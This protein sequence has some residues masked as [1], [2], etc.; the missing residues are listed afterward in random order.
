MAEL[1]LRELAKTYPGGTRAVAGVSLHVGERE[2]VVLVGP[3]GC[4][5]TTLLRL[6]AGLE[7]ATAGRVLLGGRDVTATPPAARNVAMVFQKYA[8]Y[9]FKSVAENLA[10]GPRLR[11]VPHVEVEQRVAETAD[12]LGLRELLS[13]YPSQLSGGQQQRVALGRALVRRPELFLFDEPLSNLDANLRRDLRSEIRLLQRESATAAVYVTHDQEEAMAL[14]DRLV[15]MHC[16]QF[17]QTGTPQQVY[18][19]PADRFVA[20]FF[21]SPPMNFLAGELRRGDAGMLWRSTTLPALTLGAVP[22]RL[23]SHPGRPVVLGF[24]PESLR[25]GRNADAL[26]LVLRV[27][28]VE[29]LG[30]HTDVDLLTGGGERVTARVRGAVPREGDE[31]TMHVP[32]SACHWFDPGSEGAALA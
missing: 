15:V 17:L 7:E 1:I 24:R 27:R 19:R 5:K 30:E 13:A 20:G 14:A 18:E 31:V 8:L 25:M 6:I 22:E 32:P 2:F 21:G 29:P 9:P 4:G 12:R 3:S 16:G 26:S 10:F 11:G 28:N 23:A